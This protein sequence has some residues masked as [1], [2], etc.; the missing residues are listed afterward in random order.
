MSNS[1]QMHRQIERGC[2]ALEILMAKESA[3]S[4]IVENCTKVVS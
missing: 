1:V 4:I 3:N 2:E